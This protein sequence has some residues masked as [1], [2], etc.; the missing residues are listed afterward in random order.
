[1]NADE[2]RALLKKHGTKAAAARAAKLPVST[3]NDRLNGRPE[4]TSKRASGVV[5]AIAA[6]KTGGRS[7]SEFRSQFDKSFIIPGKLRAALRSLGN[8]WEYEVQLAKSAGV[9][10]SDLG[11][12]RDEFSAHIVVLNRESRRAWAGTAATAQAMRE[13]L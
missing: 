7:L 2:A 5:P 13:M 3:F 1:M 4:T 12:Y 6:N 11:N 8:G 9:S 10:L